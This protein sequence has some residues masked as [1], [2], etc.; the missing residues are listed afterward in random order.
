MRVSTTA[1]VGNE[2]QS[3]PEVWND[4]EVEWFDHKG[5]DADVHCG[6]NRWQLCGQSVSMLPL[7]KRLLLFA[8]Q[9]FTLDCT[10][11]AHLKFLRL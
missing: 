3:F 10:R 4:D 8:L 5:Q 9:A 2:V 1:S 7:R 11:I 6:M